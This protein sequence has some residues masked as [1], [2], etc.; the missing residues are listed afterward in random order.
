MAFICPY[1]LSS[2]PPLEYHEDGKV[3]LSCKNCG[4]PIEA[5]S[6]SGG[7]GGAR[8]PRILC[9]DDDRLLLALFTDVLEVHGFEPLTARDGATGIEAAK[10]QQPDLILLDVMMP[11]M[12]GFDVCRTLRS[13]PAFQKTPIVMFT[14]L[15]DPRV[16][17]QALAAGATRALQKP[18][19]PEM[20]IEVLRATLTNDSSSPPAQ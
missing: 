6:L 16:E 7:Q 15:A 13:F 20:L 11:G 4:Y 3:R 19:N 9:I 17:P 14:A 1:C 12:S 18:S 2:Q 5:A 8:R 10:K